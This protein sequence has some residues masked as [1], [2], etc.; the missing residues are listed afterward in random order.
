VNVGGLAYD[1]SEEPI[2]PGLDYKH[3]S[4]STPQNQH[5]NLWSFFNPTCALFFKAIVPE[6]PE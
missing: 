5:R 2:C 6:S 4:F 1:F 3:N